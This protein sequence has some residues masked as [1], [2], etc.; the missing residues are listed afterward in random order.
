M[1]E[2]T[3]VHR[4]SGQ[5][6]RVQTKVAVTLDV[7]YTGNEIVI[8]GEMIAIEDGDQGHERTRVRIESPLKNDLGEVFRLDLVVA[9]IQL[10]E[11][12]LV[13]VNSPVTL[14]AHSVIC[15]TVRKHLCVFFPTNASRAECGKP[16]KE[17]Y[18]LRSDL[19][20]ILF[21]NYLI[22][23]VLNGRSRLWSKWRE[24]TVS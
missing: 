15:V 10:P 3:A 8:G 11:C 2:K 22:G 7:G 16:A 19:P 5:F 4:V 24:F 18:P 20:I 12:F 9:A 23:M 1:A 21:S 14:Q 6:I 17:G 13:L